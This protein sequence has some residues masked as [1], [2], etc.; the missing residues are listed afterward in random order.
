MDP[1]QMLSR[2]EDAEQFLKQ[3]SNKTRLMVLCS[4]LD[5]ERSVTELLDKVPVTQPVLSQ[6]LALL[7]EAEFVATR[8]SGQTIYYRLA[9]ERITQIMNLMYTFFCAED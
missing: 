6:H 3:L 4:L 1:S 2:S 7:R 8:R 9:D 5:G